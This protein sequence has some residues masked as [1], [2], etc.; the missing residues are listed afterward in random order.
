MITNQLNNNINHDFSEHLD[1]SSRSFG[2]GFHQKDQ[3]TKM[4]EPLPIIRK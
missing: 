1:T 2:Y 4:E 3:V